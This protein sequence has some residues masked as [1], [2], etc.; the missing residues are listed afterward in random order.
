MAT[1]LLLGCQ[2]SE[3]DLGVAGPRK[4]DVPASLDHPTELQGNWQEVKGKQTILLN[5]DG[6]CEIKQNVSISAEETH[7]AAKS[8]ATKVACKWGTK[9]GKFYFTDIAGSVPL[10]YDFKITGDK[11]DMDAPGS[12]LSYTRIVDKKKAK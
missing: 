12:K 5:A 10:S 4:V 3:E 1:Q 9:D 2:K 6:S 11:V 7:G 8:F